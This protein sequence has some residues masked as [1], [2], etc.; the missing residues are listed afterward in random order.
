M[1]NRWIIFI[2]L[3]SVINGTA[4][5][6]AALVSISGARPFKVYV[7]S[8]YN[9][10]IPE[11]LII[12][13]AGL[14]QSG[15]VYE[16]YTKLTPFAQADGFLFVSP[17]GMVN[18]HGITFWSATPECC[19]FEHSGVNDDAYIIKIIDDVSSRYAVDPNRIYVI[20]HSNGGFMANAVASKNAD[21][22]AAVVD[23]SGGTYTTQAA[24][25]PSRP[26]S[27]LEI[28]GTKDQTYYGSNLS[29]KSIPG[30]LRVFNTWGSINHCTGGVVT[31][32]KK[33]NLLA[34]PPTLD[35]TVM[36]FRGC[37]SSTSVEF[38]SAEGSIHAPPV[39]PA[40]NR[41]MIVWLLAHPKISRH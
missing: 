38:W 20:G 4:V 37:P 34:P 21:R 12:S 35:A 14:T 23:F 19:D 13:I 22:V 25:K 7:S 29:G 39:T 9:P 3:M 17:D 41:Q 18:S 15:A 40:F 6:S 30:A 10:A 32:H 5:S 31:L 16:K 28:W 36:K 11:P 8:K 33:I 27:V 26:I 1:K 2:A 24:C